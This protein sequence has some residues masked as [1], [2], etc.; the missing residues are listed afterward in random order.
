[1][2]TAKDIESEFK[3]RFQELLNEFEADFEAADHFMG[4]S[5]CGQDI[6]CRIQGYA[7]YDSTGA[8][9]REFFDF[10]L[11]TIIQHAKL[12]ATQ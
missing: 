2:K 6:Q 10:D 5:E 3:R 12:G 4:Y 11:G 1:M 9:I 8:V 7:H